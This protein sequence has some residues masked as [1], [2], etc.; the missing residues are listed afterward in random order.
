[1]HEQQ[2]LK[3]ALHE[4]TLS[5][6]LGK[7]RFLPPLSPMGKIHLRP[8]NPLILRRKKFTFPNSL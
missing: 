5:A 8:L 4:L 3:L 2:C 6:V 1:M 7:G